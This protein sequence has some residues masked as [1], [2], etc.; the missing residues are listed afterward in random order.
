[1]SWFTVLEIAGILFVA[2]E[3]LTAHFDKYNSFRAW[4]EG[5]PEERLKRPEESSDDEKVKIRACLTMLE[6]MSAG[7]GQGM[8]SLDY[9]ANVAN[10]N[11]RRNFK[12]LRLHIKHIRKMRGSE[13]IYDGHEWLAFEL[14]AQSAPPEKVFPPD[15]RSRSVFKPTKDFLRIRSR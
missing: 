13:K 7:I 9:V 3:Y 5:F 1:M 6:R 2:L 4:L 8:F 14:E 12:S 11:L 15:W 10:K